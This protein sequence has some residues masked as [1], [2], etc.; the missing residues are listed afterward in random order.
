MMSPLLPFLWLRAK[1][2]EWAL[3]YVPPLIDGKFN[4]EYQKLSNYINDER[5]KRYMEGK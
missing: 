4:P 5:V 3:N 1:Y 2:A